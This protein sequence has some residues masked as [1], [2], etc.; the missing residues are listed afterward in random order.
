M[1][2]ASSPQRII[3]FL[4]EF[5][6]NASR[7]IKYYELVSIPMGPMNANEIAGVEERIRFIYL[8]GNLKHDYILIWEDSKTDLDEA[9]VVNEE[10]VGK[11]NLNN[12]IWKMVN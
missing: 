8:G 4:H 5:K 10:Y 12:P 2:G 6:Q 3:G 1:I 7:E 11:F 9:A